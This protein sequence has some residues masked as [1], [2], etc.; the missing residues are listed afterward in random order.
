MIP[1]NFGESTWPLE[2]TWQ[3][4]NNTGHHRQIKRLGQWEVKDHWVT[5]TNKPDVETTGVEKPLGTTN[6]RKARCG[7]HCGMKNQWG[8]KN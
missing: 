2:A 5:K 1:L 3:Y 4:M 7:D 6:R 8:N